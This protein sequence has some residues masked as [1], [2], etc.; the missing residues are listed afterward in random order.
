MRI[1]HELTTAGTARERML[2]ALCRTGDRPGEIEDARRYIADAGYDCLAAGLA[3][4]DG[5]SSGA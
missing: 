4:A 5:L 3:G 2:F 1:A